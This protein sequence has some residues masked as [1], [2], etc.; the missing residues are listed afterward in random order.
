MRRAFRYFM[1]P[2]LQNQKKT[3][4]LKSNRLSF[5]SRILESGERTQSSHSH[6]KTFYVYGS[7][8]SIFGFS[9]EKPKEE[10]PILTTIKNAILS[11]QHGDYVKAD[12]L[13][14]IAL[15]QAQVARQ[16]EAVTHVYCLMANLAMERKF[17]GQAEKLFTTVLSRLLN[18]GEPED[19]NAVLE[20]SLK[21][22]QIFQAKGDLPKA[23]AG[24]NYCVNCKRKKLA[25]LNGEAPDEDTLA[26]FGMSLDL[27]AQFLFS[28]NKLRE[29][30][31]VWRE[32]VGV[33]KQLHGV[34]GEQVLV[35]SNSL[36]LA[37]SAQE[38]REKEAAEMLEDL[39]RRAGKIQSTHTS[40][41]LINLGLLRLKQGLLEKAKLNCDS[42]KRLAT[43]VSDDEA[44]AE[45]EEC[46]KQVNMLLS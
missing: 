10:D 3:N 45:A 46:L 15:Q 27:Q 24:F 4:S 5:Y 12:K 40:S 26:L 29:A 41:F 30:E 22:A 32:A 31:T 19:S 18:N 9:Q 28:T 33:G 44:T 8:L 37:I 34:D 2:I 16:E 38:G 11:I 23:E 6:S 17:Y 1:V 25:K 39:V 35:V 20:I 43:A 13:L 21:I 14:H 7:I 42:A 36:A